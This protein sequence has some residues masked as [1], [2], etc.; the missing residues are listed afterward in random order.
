[1]TTC[2]PEKCRY[3]RI[4]FAS[5]ADPDGGNINSS[6]ISMFLDFYR[7]LVE[8]GMVFVTLPP[9]FVV[10]DAETRIYCQD[11]A[12]RDTAVAHLRA[13]SKRKVE[14][15]RN[16]GLGEMN[17]DDFWATVLDPSQRTV[18]RISPDDTAQA[19]HQ[20]PSAVRRRAGATGWP[21][22]PPVST[23]PSS[24]SAKELPR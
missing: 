13:T 19:L 14:V 9:L 16:K 3:D 20:T 1:M 21:R 17:A 23:P 5:D 18:Y 11:E 8:A 4:L 7:P 24:T 15:Q 10:H 12:E 2:D 22:P 6:L